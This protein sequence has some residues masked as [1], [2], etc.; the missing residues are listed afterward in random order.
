MA[1]AK[2]KSADACGKDADT[3]TNDGSETYALLC[4]FLDPAFDGQMKKQQDQDLAERLFEE[5]VD[6]WEWTATRVKAWAPTLLR[7]VTAK[8]MA[9]Q[10]TK[11]GE[12]DMFYVTVDPGLFAWFVETY[13]QTHDVVRLMLLELEDG[14]E[15]MEAI[16]QLMIE[17]GL[18]LPAAMTQAHFTNAR[19]ASCGFGD[20]AD[21]LRD[22]LSLPKAEPKA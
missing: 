20:A 17:K 15:S 7:C 18:Q 12:T 11:F 13:G 6:I 1:A 10:A 8:T 2:P 14:P 3:D 19:L 4:A 9:L 22:M 5:L 21:E 16:V